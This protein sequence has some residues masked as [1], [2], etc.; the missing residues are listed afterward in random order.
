[1]KTEKNRETK[2]PTQR[3]VKMTQENSCAARLRQ[4]AS[5]LSYPPGTNYRN[6]GESKH[7]LGN[8]GVKHITKKLKMTTK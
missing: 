6:A 8:L 2:V 4:S 5:P 3:K 7:V 1:M